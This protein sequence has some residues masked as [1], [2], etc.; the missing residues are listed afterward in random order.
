MEIKNLYLI[1][2]VLSFFIFGLYYIPL[3]MKSKRFNKFDEMI[4]ESF[5]DGIRH[6]I[7]LG[8]IIISSIF[9][10][11]LF[12]VI[13]IC[14]YYV[15][16]NRKLNKTLPKGYNKI[17][18]WRGIDKG[19][20]EDEELISYISHSLTEEVVYL[21]SFRNKLGTEDIFMALPEIENR[22]TNPDDLEYG[23]EFLSNLTE[24]DLSNY[25][26]RVKDYLEQEK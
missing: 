18:V 1:G 3:I 13:S 12:V 9:T 22:S 16:K 10:S 21:E 6:T 24:E 5:G 26:R 25:P 2:V 19:K 11:W 7:V 23:I 14:V 8:M 17:I 20:C 4:T 15:R